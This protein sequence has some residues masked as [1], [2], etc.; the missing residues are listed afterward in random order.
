MIHDDCSALLAPL[1]S[2]VWSFPQFK[3][4][5][6]FSKDPQQF[7]HE[8]SSAG[9]ARRLVSSSVGGAALSTSVAVWYPPMHQNYLIV[10]LDNTSIRTALKLWVMDK[11]KA[12]HRYGHISL[13]DT[14][15]V[16]NMGNLFRDQYCFN[17]DISGWDVSKVTDMRNM[18]FSAESFNQ[19][20]GAWNTSSVEDMC[21]LFFNATSFNQPLDGW[22]V[23]SVE[24]MGHMFG[25]TPFDQPLS[26][27]NVSSVRRMG[28]MF[29]G[30]TA[31]NQ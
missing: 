5:T 23:S 15:L 3:R 17:D 30:A 16:T 2:P 9:P 14:H 28:S 20:I 13:W 4:T 24:H 31:F 27:W 1:L 7:G 21:F 12:A 11:R 29:T 18:F 26:S 10:A 19:P 6:G 8:V 25:M 22:D